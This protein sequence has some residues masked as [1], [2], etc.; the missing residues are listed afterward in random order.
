MREVKAEQHLKRFVTLWKVREA[1]KNR[2]EENQSSLFVLRP[3]N[4]I[5]RTRCS[6]VPG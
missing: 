3:K 6:K 4:E 5:A 2:E 1:L